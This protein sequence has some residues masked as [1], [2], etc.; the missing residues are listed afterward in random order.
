MGLFYLYLL[1]YFVMVLACLLAVPLFDRFLAQHE[2]QP[3]FVYDYLT[4]L[5]TCGFEALRMK[6]IWE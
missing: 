2:D 4:A 6:A 5:L 1:L 3:M